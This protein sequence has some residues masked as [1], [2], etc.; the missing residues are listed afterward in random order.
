MSE[1]GSEAINWV[2]QILALI[3]VGVIISM[4]FAG[5]ETLAFFG[6]SREIA[7]LV[8]FFLCP[9]LTT[10][11]VR[12]DLLA[13]GAVTNLLL[14]LLSLIYSRDVIGLDLLS[15]SIVLSFGMVSGA[16]A[17]GVI[18]RMRNEIAFVMNSSRLNNKPE[19][20]YRIISLPTPRNS[21]SPTPR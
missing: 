2:W 6:F 13:W 18:E 9:L 3:L 8:G 12:R 1:H 21:F 14:V 10:L 20:P 11:L 5:M 19:N 17:G 4:T 15:A 7:L 16:C